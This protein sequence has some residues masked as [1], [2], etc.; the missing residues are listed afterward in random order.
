MNSYELEALK[1]GFKI[2]AGVD[3]AGRG[4]LA[5]PVVAAAVIFPFDA[6]NKPRE[7]LNLGI[8]DSKKLTPL[9]RENLCN[10]IFQNARSVGIG[11]AW[12]DYIEQVNINVATQKAMVNAVSKLMPSPD[13]LLIDGI[14]GIPYNI[15]QRTIIGGDAASVSVAAA[16]IIAKVARDRIMSGYHNLLPDYRFAKHKGYGTLD[17][18]TFIEKYGPSSI[19]RRGFKGVREHT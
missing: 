18:C 14:Y 1:N 2:I 4:P 17:H 15:S 3:E 10:K 6:C 9:K 13:F 5:G 11:I 19:H 8:N 16:S 7:F 12:P